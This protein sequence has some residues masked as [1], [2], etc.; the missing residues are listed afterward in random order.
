M[1]FENRIKSLLPVLEL[2]SN[3]AKGFIGT[4]GE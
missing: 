4:G 2:N 1:K 3:D